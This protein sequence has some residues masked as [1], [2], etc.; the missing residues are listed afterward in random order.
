MSRRSNTIPEDVFNGWKSF[1]SITQTLS[2]ISSINFRNIPFGVGGKDV[3]V[4]LDQFNP[5]PLIA[6]IFEP[7]S[8]LDPT[9]DGT[10][11][12]VSDLLSGLTPLAL[13]EDDSPS[14]IAL[15][16]TSS[17]KPTGKV[18]SKKADADSPEDKKA[19]AKGKARPKSSA[20][21]TSSNKKAA[22]ERVS[23]S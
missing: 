13:D 12:A 16:S 4:E 2:G 19:K 17:R 21:T 5:F 23:S 1:R 8:M 7:L 6:H 20:K 15:G 18:Q 14:N 10:S 9:A 11:A 22:P 3:V